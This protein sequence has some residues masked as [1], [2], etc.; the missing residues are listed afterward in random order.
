MKA[1]VTLSVLFC[2]VFVGFSQ[3]SKWII[4]F[5]DK[6]NSPYSIENPGTYLSPKAIARRNR[7]HIPVDDKDFPVN[8]DYIPQVLSKG[9][10]TFLSESKWL[11]Q[12]LIYCTD[13]IAVNSIKSLSFVKALRPA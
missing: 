7:Y 10:I 8:P 1:L 13:S 6:K 3:Y 9:N 2:F 4:Q 11:N 5:A 12:I